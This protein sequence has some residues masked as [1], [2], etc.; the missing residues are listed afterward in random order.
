MTAT[1]AE[2]RRA[3]LTLFDPRGCPD[4]YPL[5]A[6]LRDEAPVYRTPEGTVIVSRFTECDRVL[7]DSTFRVED[8][9][10]VARTL[11]E[12]KDNIT[13][14]SL[15]GE[16][17][18]KNS[19]HHERLRRLVSKAF[20]P[21]RVAGLRPAVERLVDQLLD[22]MQ[23]EAAEGPVDLM[24]RFALP[25]PV[26]VIGELL[27]IPENERAWFGPRVETVTAAIER[28]LSEPYLA[29]SDTAMRELWD[30]LGKLA[31]DRRAAPRDDMLSTLIKARD[32]DGDRLSERE[33][34]ANLVLL[35][36]AGYETTS[37]LIG[38]GLVAL[39]ERPELLA[40]LRAEPDGIDAWIE[41]MLRFDPPVQIAS[42]WA[43]TDT[44]LGGE[45]VGEGTYVIALLASGNR[46]PRRFDDPESFVPG[47]S[48]GSSLTFGAG[49]HFCLGAALARME[50]QI[51]FPRLL[52]RFEDI[53]HANG[54]AQ[55][56][57]WLTALRGYPELP[58]KL[59]PR[60]T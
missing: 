3:V 46:D 34:L 20:T 51:A 17:V 21:R 8:E 2:L 12:R 15:M 32:E 31:A 37:N 22:G 58:L 28:D 13:V 1:A 14:V 49:A 40:R 57:S 42:R 26:T 27:G 18:N 10:F 38:N 9:D 35:Y 19:P 44:E 30:R 39:L 25:L 56:R 52:E 36:S 5:Y 23:A 29:A 55:P 48:E 53:V 7:R 41:E 47:R 43:G 60:G 24:S 16:M 6:L 59:V 45:P 33:L 54:P 4:P 11:P 50:A